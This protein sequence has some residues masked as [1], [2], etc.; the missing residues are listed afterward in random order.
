MAKIR[1]SHS[2]RWGEGKVLDNIPR[3]VYILSICSKKEAVI[4]K[5]HL[6]LL[7]VEQLPSVPRAFRAPW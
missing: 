6:F 5:P 4:R 7:N 2:P 3:D 1:E